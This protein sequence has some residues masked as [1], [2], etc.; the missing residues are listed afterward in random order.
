MG[1]IARLRTYSGVS[2][3]QRKVERLLEEFEFSTI[4]AAY[5]YR[6]AHS[7]PELAGA[8]SILSEARSGDGD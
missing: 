3:M 1:L 8:A 6:P 5:P 2:G 7:G 4:S